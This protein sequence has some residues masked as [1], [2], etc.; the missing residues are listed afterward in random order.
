M[1]LVES[2]RS[3]LWRSWSVRLNVLAGVASAVEFGFSY[4]NVQL[5]GKAAL[6]AFVVSMGA[7]MA[8]LVAQP[9]LRAVLF[10]DTVPET[11]PREE[12]NAA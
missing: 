11:Q 1:K 12:Q 2:W 3:V 5:G 8:R 4:F 10:L 7:A 9:K 6:A